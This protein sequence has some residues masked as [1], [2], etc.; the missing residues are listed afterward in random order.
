LPEDFCKDIFCKYQIYLGEEEF[1]T[2]PILGKNK[3]PEFN[4][5]YQHTNESVTEL[6]VKYI[7]DDSLC[8]KVYGYPDIKTKVEAPV[9]TSAKKAVSMRAKKPKEELPV[10]LSKTSSVGNSLN[11]SDSTMSSSFDNSKTLP[12]SKASRDEDF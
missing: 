6:F 5:S 2:K 1:A 3:D 12:R 7:K 10:N 4:Y 8:I 11:N 9:K